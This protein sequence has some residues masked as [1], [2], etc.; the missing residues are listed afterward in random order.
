VLE[1]VGLISV[2]YK[3]YEYEEEHKRDLLYLLENMFDRKRIYA[4]HS[5]NSHP[6]P[7]AQ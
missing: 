6:N 7:K 2:S 4:N 1:R 5:S 3:L